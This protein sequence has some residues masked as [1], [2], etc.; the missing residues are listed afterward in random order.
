MLFRNKIFFILSIIFVISS[1]GSKSS[2]SSNEA[3]QSINITISGAVSPSDS[4]YKQEIEVSSDNKGCTYNISNLSDSSAN[5][6]H[7]NSVDN[8]VF[9]FRNPI[10]LFRP[11]RY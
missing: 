4:Y 9:T 1:C 10:N 8:K 6:L 3:D 7:L 5:I 11:I 2:L